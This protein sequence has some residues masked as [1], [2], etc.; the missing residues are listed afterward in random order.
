MIDIIKKSKLRIDAKKAKQTYAQYLEEMEIEPTNYLLKE[1]KLPKIFPVPESPTMHREASMYEG[2][3]LYLK[4]WNYWVRAGERADD[5]A[6]RFFPDFENPN[7]RI[8]AMLENMGVST[9]PATTEKVVWDRVATVW[10]WLSHNVSY[11]GEAYGT[12]STQPDGGWPSID[13]YAAYFETHGNLVWAACFSKAHL[14]A[15]ILGRIGI[16]RWHV[17]IAESHHTEGGAPP[18]A[19][20]VFVGLYIADKWLY[21]DPTWVYAVPELP[22]YFERESVGLFEKVDYTRP[23]KTIPI[24]LSGFTRVPLLNKTVVT[25]ARFIANRN[26]KEIHDLEQAVAG[27]KLD[28]IN[29]ENKLSLSTLEEVHQLMDELDFDGCRWCMGKYHSD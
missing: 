17:T 21:L 8:F 16:P 9:A 5:R 7:P 11:D 18:T 13:D 26:T 3:L 25:T 22:S 15:S 20:H 1:I 24:P 27:C 23:Y 6:T 29:A 14:F 12:I 28:Q 4:Y 10:S 2:S 19:T